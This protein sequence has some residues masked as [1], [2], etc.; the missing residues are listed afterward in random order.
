LLLFGAGTVA[1][2]VDA[3]DRGLLPP[4]IQALAASDL[5][6]AVTPDLLQAIARG[7]PNVALSDRSA[8]QFQFG[9]NCTGF[10]ASAIRTPQGL[11]AVSGFSA[12]RGAPP[13][14]TKNG[15]TYQGVE[16]D[17]NGGPFGQIGTSVQ[18]GG[19][20]ANRRVT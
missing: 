3:A 5:D 11:A 17:V 12:M 18:T 10:I 14:A 7:L 9:L 19:Q 1:L 15:F 16:H 13:P 4:D 20:S 8:D 6:H 2:P